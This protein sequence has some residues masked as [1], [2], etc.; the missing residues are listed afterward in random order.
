MRLLRSTAVIGALTLVSRFFGLARD[1]LLASR[2]GAGPLTDAFLVA[3]QFPNLFRRIFA[4]GAFN[5]A[6]V[7]LYARRLEGEGPDAA[8]VFA[9]EVLSVLTTIVLT[10]V[11][12]A[13]IAMPWLMYVL[14]PGFIADP[15]LFGFA[16]LMTQITMPYLLCMS[17]AAMLSGALNSHERFVAAAAAPVL[18]NIVLITLLLIDPGDRADLALALSIGVTASG[19]LQ[20]GFLFLAA[21]RAGIKLGFRLPR[22]TPGVR[23]LLT[24]GLPGAAAAGVT[25]INQLVSGSIATLQEGARSWIYFAERLY[26]L[27]LGVI[28]IAMGVALL[29]AL[30]KR[31]R[32]GDDAAAAMGQNRAIEISLALTL[33]AAAALLVIPDLIV[34]GL[35]RFGAF[36]GDDARN[37]AIAVAIYGAGLPGFVLIKVFSPGFFAREDTV[38]PMKF[39]GLSMLVNV[40]L[41]VAL[42]FGPMRFAGLAA[43]TSAAGWLNA[44]LLAITLASRG[45]FVPDARLR[46]RLPRILV[47]CAAMAA[48]V[49]IAARNAAAGEAILAGFVPGEL[50]ATLYMALVVLGG[51]L[52]YGLAA[53]ATGALRIG[54]LRDTLRPAEGAAP[55]P[56]VE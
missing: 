28:G 12:V 48:A 1:M 24:L 2:L 11:V 37:T 53:M 3:L 36:A 41:G 7:P 19:V 15:D 49:W 47:A 20:A 26:Q 51:G 25:H 16:V 44:G 4:E 40:A 34:D 56:P 33:P 43:A 35:F 52:V 30:S 22:P 32:A 9:S 14:G 38:T 10:L 39:A 23:R 5:S 8:G 17:I 13:Q 31:L 55:P 27:P 18:L 6:F 46:Q 21:R 42:F 29:P 50:E 54:E 45:Q